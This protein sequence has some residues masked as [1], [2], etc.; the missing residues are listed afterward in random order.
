M[1]VDLLKGRGP[2][3]EAQVKL[4]LLN[5]GTKPLDFTLT[6]HDHVGGTQK[7]TVAPGMRPAGLGWMSVCLVPAGVQPAPVTR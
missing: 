6:A 1:K 4:M 5:D 3:H 7:V 2:R